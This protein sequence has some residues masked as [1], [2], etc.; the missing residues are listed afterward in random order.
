MAKKIRLKNLGFATTRCRG[1]GG[2]VILY[3][4]T[5]K[6]RL[7]PEDVPSSDHRNQEREAPRGPALPKASSRRRRSQTQWSTPTQDGL[8][9]FRSASA[10]VLGPKIAEGEAAHDGG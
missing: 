7:G 10:V 8:T 9:F 6:S 4:S 2:E 1:T 5:P 3:A